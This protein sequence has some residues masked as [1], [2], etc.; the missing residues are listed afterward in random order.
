MTEQLYLIITEDDQ[1]L[2]RG[3]TMFEAENALCRHINLGAEN[4][5]IGEDDQDWI[6]CDNRLPVIDYSKAE[7][8]RYVTC[9]VTTSA[10]WVLSASYTSNGYAKTAKGCLPRWHA[11]GR[12]LQGVIAWKPIPEAA[13]GLKK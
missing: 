9:L 2:Q 6:Y 5:F 8:A 7:Y 3:L 13:K 11:S 10:D 12:I 1:I 4:A